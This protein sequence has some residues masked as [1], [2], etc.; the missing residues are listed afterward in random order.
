MLRLG[1][2]VAGAAGSPEHGIGAQ[3]VHTTC[4]P[5]VLA[6]DVRLRG[7]RRGLVAG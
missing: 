1:E 2:Q 4:V 7:G 5:G 3:H 6:Q